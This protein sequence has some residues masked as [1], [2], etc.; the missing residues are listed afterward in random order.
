MVIAFH[1]YERKSLAV[2]GSVGGLHLAAS[3]TASFAL[4]P[5]A[6]TL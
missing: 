1:G 3:L 4:F 2:I 5:Q 6:L